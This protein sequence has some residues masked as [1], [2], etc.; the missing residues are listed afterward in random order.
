[1]FATAQ[2]E[3]IYIAVIVHDK[4]GHGAADRERRERQ[5]PELRRQ[6]AAGWRLVGH[7]LPGGRVRDG[8]RLDC[9]PLPCGRHQKPRHG[10][11]IAGLHGR[12]QGGAEMGRK[13]HNR[14]V[15]QQ[16]SLH[17]AMRRQ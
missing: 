4:A 3:A 13:S 11:R 5:P 2:D 12:C 1:M 14:A 15:G 7:G 6:R 8:Q 17:L 10:H 16:Q 9:L